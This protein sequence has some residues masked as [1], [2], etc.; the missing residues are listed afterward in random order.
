M[1]GKRVIPRD[2][3]VARIRA[4]CEERDTG[5]PSPPA[6]GFPFFLRSTLIVG[7]QE[8]TFLSSH[9]LTRDVSHLKKH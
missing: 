4:A 7:R 9:G 8:S 2:E 1:D 6:G 3:A 5:M